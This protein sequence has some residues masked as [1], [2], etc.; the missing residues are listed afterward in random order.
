MTTTIERPAVLGQG[1]YSF[2]QAREILSHRARPITT[3]RLRHW[4]NSGLSPASHQS[5]TGDPILN[6][7]DLVSLE[8]VG[9]FTESG[10]SVQRVRE[11][12]RALRDE[13]P[14][15]DRPFAYEIFYTDGAD[16]WAQR[17]G[18]DGAVVMVEL[19][20]KKANAR[21]KHVVWSDAIRTFA[22]EIRFGAKHE[23]IAWELSPWVEI[24]P[25][26]QFGAPTVRGTRVTVRT[27]IANLEAGT[28]AEVA[29]WYG[30][31]VEQVEGARD[32][33]AVH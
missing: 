16:V 17:F 14:G 21:E 4:M 13:F 23:A 5:S 18:E 9:R 8:M 24:D 6:F 12:E 25:G 1:V 30:L 22:S 11:F 28:P 27:V 19:L 26:V 29:E 15:V 7:H 32:Y 10:M 3:R 31:S 2:P 33:V 20:G